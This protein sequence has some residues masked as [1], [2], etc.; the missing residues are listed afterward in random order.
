MPDRE[1][2]GDRPTTPNGLAHV[3]DYLITTKYKT[4]LVK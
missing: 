4:D 3:D 2:G 1:R